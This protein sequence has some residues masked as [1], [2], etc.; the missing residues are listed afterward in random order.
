M[1]RAR[2]LLAKGE[3]VDA[4]LEALARGLTQKMLHG[5]MAEL[6]AADA[7]ARERRHRDAA[8]LPAQRALAAVAG[9]SFPRR[10]EPRAPWLPPSLP[11]YRERSP[12]RFPAP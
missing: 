10:R 11:A 12:S 3:N 8:F 9:A 7:E 4:V 6:H 5:A 1:A 2:K